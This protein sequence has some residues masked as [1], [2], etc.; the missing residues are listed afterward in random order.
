MAHMQHSGGIVEAV[1]ELGFD[2]VKYFEGDIGTSA[3]GFS[4]TPPARRLILN[5]KSTSGNLYLRVDGQNA[6]ASTSFVPGDNI[7]IVPGANFTMDFDALH[8]ISL[9]ADASP[10]HA[11]G[12]LGWKGTQ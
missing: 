9:I 5:N 1:L 2:Q 4:I 8:S 10:V 12:I 11:E 6:Q 7:K 3:T